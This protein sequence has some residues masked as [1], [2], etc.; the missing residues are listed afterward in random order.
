MPI[1]R[2]LNMALAVGML[3]FSVMS[4]LSFNFESFSLIIATV[5]FSVYQM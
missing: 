1:V 5:V 4:I 2:Y 3:I